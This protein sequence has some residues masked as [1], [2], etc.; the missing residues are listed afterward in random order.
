MFVFLISVI[1]GFSFSDGWLSFRSAVSLPSL[2]RVIVSVVESWC[3]VPSVA[4]SSTSCPVEFG[5]LR[6]GKLAFPRVW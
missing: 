2:G 1:T 4:L 3:P 5:D 6:P